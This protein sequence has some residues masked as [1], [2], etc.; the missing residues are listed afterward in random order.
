MSDMPGEQE[1][2]IRRRGRVFAF[3]GGLLD[4]FRGLPRPKILKLDAKGRIVGEI[5]IE[6]PAL[7]GARQRAM[8][9]EEGL[10]KSGAFRWSGT[11]NGLA[12]ESARRIVWVCPPQPQC[13]SRTVWT[14]GRNSPR[15]SCGW[16][17][18][19]GGRV[20]LLDIAVRGKVA[21]GA[22]AKRGLVRFDLPA[23]VK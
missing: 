21:Y 23:S 6:S 17:D 1:A 18:P 12:I 7:D 22:V 10:K 3:D 16:D 11:L 8:Q 14:R 5:A 2:A 9:M 4:T 19:A 20:A 13:C 15:T